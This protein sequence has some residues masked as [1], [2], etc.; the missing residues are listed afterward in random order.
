MLGMGPFFQV[1]GAFFC[2]GVPFCFFGGFLG[3]GA[4]AWLQAVV[5]VLM[6]LISQRAGASALC[7]GFHP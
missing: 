1:A 6:G 7:S 3:W 2:G 5:T 4:A